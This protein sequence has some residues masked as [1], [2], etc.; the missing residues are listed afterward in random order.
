MLLTSTTAEVK[1]LRAA[2]SSITSR[3]PESKQVLENLNLLCMGEKTFDE[4]DFKS[5]LVEVF[6]KATEVTKLKVNLPFKIVGQVPLHATTL[7]ANLLECIACRNASEKHVKITTLVLT[8]LSDTTLNKIYGNPLDL[9]NALSVFEPLQHT[10]INIKRQEYDSA[11]QASFGA[12]FQRL[13]TEAAGLRSLCITGWNCT[14]STRQRAAT[15]GSRVE[16]DKWAAQC[17]P[18]ARLDDGKMRLA[19]LKYLELK[20]VDIDARALMAMLVD[21]SKSLKEVYLNQVYLKHDQL[22][23]AGQPFLW[24]GHEVDC[25]K[26]ADDLWIADEI[27]KMIDDGNLHLEILRASALGY[28]YIN[29]VHS[30]GNFDLEDPSGANRS[31]DERFVQRAMG[32]AAPDIGA[33]A[34]APVNY[35]VNATQIYHNTT[36]HYANTLDGLFHTYGTQALGEVVRVVSV[37]DESMKQL[38]TQLNIINGSVEGKPPVDDDDSDEEDDDVAMTGGN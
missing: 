33:A 21:C 3:T 25:D 26:R 30:D 22:S 23:I 34:V 2:F 38:T 6:G 8:H 17:L 32:L 14:R 29:T 16:R 35:D 7:F 31:F 10:M 24:V 27:K 36:S 12:G 19:N 20:R 13:L 4:A 15:G 11:S 28:D 18:Y 5:I 1:D 37:V 9:R